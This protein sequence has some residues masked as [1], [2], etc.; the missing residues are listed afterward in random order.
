MQAKE[1]VG[2]SNRDLIY[3]LDAANQLT[4]EFRS[5]IAGYTTTSIYDGAGNRLTNQT[6]AAS[7]TTFTFDA[8]NQ[9]TKSVLG[10]VTTTYTYDA[11]GNQTVEQIG[12]TFTTQT[13]DYENRLTLVQKAGTTTNTYTFDGDGKRVRIDDSLTTTGRS[14]IWSGQNILREVN[15]SGGTERVLYTL[16]PAGYGNLFSQRRSGTT[17]YYHSDALGSTRA[18]T[19]STGATTDTYT[20]Y[21]F[22]LTVTSTGTTEN[23]FRWVGKLGYYWDTDRLVYY[24][25][26]R[27]YSP[28]LARFL[29]YD[30]IGVAGGLNLF[31]YVGNKPLVLVDPGG[32]EPETFPVPNNPPTK[33]WDKFDVLCAH[34]CTRC[35]AD[36]KCSFYIDIWGPPG[37]P[38]GNILTKWDWNAAI[39]FWSMMDRPKDT[40]LREQCS[41]DLNRTQ[42]EGSLV[43]E[44]SDGTSIV[45]TSSAF[46]VDGNIRPDTLPPIA[47]NCLVYGY[48]IGVGEEVTGH[49]EAAVRCLY[50]KSTS[51]CPTLLRVR[52]DFVIE[53]ACFCGGTD[54]WNLSPRLAG[55]V[56][57]W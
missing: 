35:K 3:T 26:A 37:F 27:P 20:Y 57:I 36:Q 38:F 30:P 5:G 15:V 46:D 54:T 2:S 23:T 55:E 17:T 47:R 12:N 45:V 50:W 24:L 9:L 41:A 6:G 1:I 49:T 56:S 8:A 44:L 10:T 16:E 48:G 13:W 51:E 52:W 29:S 4:G 53:W 25:R 34:E 21:A 19:N 40:A 31:G 11:R 28:K 43:F 33:V 14:L 7:I 39:C 22:G 42:G 18:L 32:K